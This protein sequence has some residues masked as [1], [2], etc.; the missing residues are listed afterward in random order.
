[1]FEH[2][3]AVQRRNDGRS[4]ADKVVTLQRYT[5]VLYLVENCHYLGMALKA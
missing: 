1:V 5:R 3:N 4:Y 2:S